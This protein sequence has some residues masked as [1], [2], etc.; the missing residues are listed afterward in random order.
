MFTK[1]NKGKHPKANGVTHNAPMHP[2]MGKSHMCTPG[3]PKNG[4][5]K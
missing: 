4:Y 5:G 3:V 2:K 1:G